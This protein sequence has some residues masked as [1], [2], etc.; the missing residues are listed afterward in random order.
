[1]KD[2]KDRLELDHR[3]RDNG[4]D[5]KLFSSEE[6]RDKAE[7]VLKKLRQGKDRLRID[8]RELR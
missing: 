7:W 4:I 8:P 1:M 2:V 6:A 5:A 3:L